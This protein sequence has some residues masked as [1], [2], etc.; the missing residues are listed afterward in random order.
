MLIKSLLK[1]LF[2]SPFKILIKALF[3]L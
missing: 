1:T 3:L 2:L